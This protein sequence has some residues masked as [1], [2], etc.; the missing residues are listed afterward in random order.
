MMMI[1]KWIDKLSVGVSAEDPDDLIILRRII[2]KGDIITADTTRVLKRDKV[3]ARPDK[4]ERIRVRIVLQVEKLSLDAMLDRLRI[5]GTIQ[6]TSNEDLAKSGHHSLSLKINQRVKITKQNWHPIEKK[7]LKSNQHT[8]KYILIAI[9][10][11]ECGIAKLDGVHLDILPN[12]D[13]GASGKRY[14]SDFD[15]EKYLREIQGIIQEISK[16]RNRIVIFGPGETKKLLGKKLE[17]QQIK[18]EIIDGIDSAGEDGI[19]IFVKS[20]V[21]SNIMSDTKLASVHKIIEQ[22][23]RLA[24]QK[25]KRFTM[26]IDD[27]K[28]ANELGAVESII[29]SD[30][31][32]QTHDEQ[33]VINLLNDAENNGVITYGVDNT[34]D[35]GMRVSGLGGMI[36]LLRYSIE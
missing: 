16:D 17:T 2:T 30:K 19:H 3:N 4:G 1:T 28:K 9:D 23:I 15:V 18:I 32:I 12:V 22:V 36:S 14:K 5:T 31:I 21:M 13:S 6:E 10:R 35:I 24:G 33:Q 20:E 34:T 26:G 7:R 29:F 11:R 8:Q 25:S 27:T